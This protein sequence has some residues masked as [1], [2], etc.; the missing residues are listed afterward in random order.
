MTT[1]S[2]DVGVAE[3]LERYRRTGDRAA[4]NEAIEAYRPLAQGLARRFGRRGETVDD[5]EQAAMLG[6]LKAAERFDP[7]GGTPF[8]VYASITVRGE[9]KRHL[10]DR[11]WRV[12]VPRRAQERSLE[13]GRA[14]EA[15]GHELGRS[16]TLP[17]M[18]RRTAAVDVER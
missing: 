16:P 15:L 18:A 3:L 6:L 12:R 11:T 14:V 10:R 7:R 1:S 9:L 17:E 8:A 2:D 4:R 5:L 13:I